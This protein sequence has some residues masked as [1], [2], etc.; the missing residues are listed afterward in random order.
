MTAEE[1]FLE[2]ID[3]KFTRMRNTMITI[4]AVIL[5]A[6]LAVGAE[7]LFRIGA[8][9]KQVTINTDLLHFVAKDYMPMMYMSDMTKLYTLHT[10]K[11]VAVLKGNSLMSDEVRRI[12]TDFENTIQI[13]QNL[14]IQT[15]GGVTNTTR[16]IKP[17]TQGGSN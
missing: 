12:D 15:R 13:M 10:E 8:I 9:D 11:V 14:L 3:R 16:S 17:Q 6:F 7:Q 1:K 5:A 2:S 4:I